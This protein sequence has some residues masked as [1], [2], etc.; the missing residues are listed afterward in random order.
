[1]N[2]RIIRISS[3]LYIT[4]YSYHSD[5]ILIYAFDLYWVR[6]RRT[7]LSSSHVMHVLVSQCSYFFAQFRAVRSM[8]VSSRFLYLISKY[9]LSEV[10]QSVTI[11]YWSFQGLVSNQLIEHEREWKDDI[12]IFITTKPPWI[13]VN[14]FSENHLDCSFTSLSDSLS[15]ISCLLSCKTYVITKWRLTFLPFISF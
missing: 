7:S 14:I 11:N 6:V 5:T 15:I 1:M 10:D 9:Q 4:M 2:M 13:R 3:I 8:V 12:K